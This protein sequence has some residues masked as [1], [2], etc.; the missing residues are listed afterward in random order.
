[1]TR[2]CSCL[3]CPDYLGAVPLQE[4]LR[5]SLLVRIADKL[6]EGGQHPSPCRLNSALSPSRSKA[7]FEDTIPGDALPLLDGDQ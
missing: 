3:F 6:E 7:Q 4:Q 2:C 5:K 1:M